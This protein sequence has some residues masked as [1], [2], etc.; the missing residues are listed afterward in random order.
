MKPTS[1][2]INFIEKQKSK[3]T[4]IF[5]NFF[6]K[7][8]NAKFYKNLKFI[9]HYIGLTGLITLLFYW[10]F[11]FISDPHPTFNPKL[12]IHIILATILSFTQN[13]LYYILITSQTP[14]FVQITGILL[15]PTITLIEIVTHGFKGYFNIIG[16][17]LIFI[18]F[19]VIN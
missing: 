19:I 7:R 10:P 1:L 15:Q 12:I 9:K 18:S 11:I 6:K 16:F 8:I 5:K 14:Q 17:I 13:I 3:K 2:Q 4:S